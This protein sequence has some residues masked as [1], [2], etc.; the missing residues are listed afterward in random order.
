MARLDVH[1][2]LLMRLLPSEGHCRPPLAV[3]RLSGDLTGG[4]LARATRPLGSGR[5]PPDATTR[6]VGA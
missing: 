3:S 4:L 5:A 1:F 6:V 2:S